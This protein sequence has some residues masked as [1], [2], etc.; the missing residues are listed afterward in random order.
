MD[1]FGL[2]EEVTSFIIESAR[3][4]A[5]DAVVLFGSRATGSFSQKSDIDLALKG[6]GIHAY[7]AA[8]EERCPTLL[9]FD[10]I[11]LDSDISPQLR[12]RIAREGVILY[13]QV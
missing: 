6:A 9:T 1:A 8:L 3:D 7:E 13:G 2:R 11:D 5:M 12:D 4:L 10:F